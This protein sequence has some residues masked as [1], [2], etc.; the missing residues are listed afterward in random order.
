[1]QAFLILLQELR[2]QLQQ[3]AQ[4]VAYGEL[5]ILMGQARQKLA[6]VDLTN[7]APAACCIN[8]CPLKPYTVLVQPTPNLVDGSVS[9]QVLVICP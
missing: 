8:H 1:M 7:Q 5:I 3:G 4:N 2:E 6:D 9:Q